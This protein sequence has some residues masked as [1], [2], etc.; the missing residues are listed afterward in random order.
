[1]LTTSFVLRNSDNESKTSNA[2]FQ[3]D[4][5]RD[6]IRQFTRFN[7]EIEDDKTFQYSVNFNKQFG[8]NSQHVL[9]FDFQYEN[10]EE[11]QFSLISNDAIQSQRVQSLEDQRRILL[12][13]DY[14]L[15]IGDVSQFELGYRGNFN[16]QDTDYTLE[17]YQNGGYVLNT[18]LSNNLI[19]TEHVNALYSQYGSKIKDKFSY[20]LGLRLEETRL[21]ID[22]ATTGDFQK[23]NYLGLFPTLNL[24]Y[25]F[26]ENQSVTLGYNRRISRPRSRFI[27]PFPSQSS[28]TTQFV[29]NPD[30]NPSYSNT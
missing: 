15:P 14:V 3:F 26:T 18:G 9:T 1:S 21:T 17:N 16:V 24:S 13:T 12:Q 22:Q 2:T 11:D 7:P 23:K 29:G 8:G 4:E 10:S 28:P 5:N 20:L 25:A 19:Y 27:N 30:I 6:L